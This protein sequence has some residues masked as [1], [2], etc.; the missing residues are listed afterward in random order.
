MK[1][2]AFIGSMLLCIIILFAPIMVNAGVS[3]HILHPGESG[4]MTYGVHLHQDPASF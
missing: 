2:K 1:L 4:G 3:T